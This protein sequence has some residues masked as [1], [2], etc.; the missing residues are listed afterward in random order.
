MVDVDRLDRVA[1]EEVDG[2][3]R[4]AEAQQVLVVDAVAD[5][6]ATVQVRRRSAG[7][8]PSRTRSSRR[9]CCRSWAGFRAWSVNVD[10]RGLD[11]LGDHGGVEA[12]ALGVRST[13][14]RRPPAAASR[15]SASRKSMPISARTRS[16]A[17]WI[18][19]SS[20]AESDLG[21]PVGHPRLRPRPLHAGGGCARG[22]R[23]RR[24]GAAA[25]PGRPPSPCPSSSGVS[26]ST[27]RSIQVVLSWV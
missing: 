20:S 25:A 7:C 8:R 18:D 23:G 3:E 10:G 27:D 2:V 11:R 9:R 17:W 22:P 5:P 21:R 16:D 26:S 19:S 15:A 24:C 14:W 4:L 6:P 13:V 12:D 1:G